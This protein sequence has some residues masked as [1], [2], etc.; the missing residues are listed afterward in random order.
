MIDR[1]L[2]LIVAS[3][4][5]VL[6]ATAVAAD[7][8]TPKPSPALAFKAQNID[9]KEVDLSRYQG[10]VLLIVNTA[11]QCGYTPQYEGLEAI[12][13]KY[14]GQ[15]FEILAFPANEFGHQEP[16]SNSEIKTFCSNNYHVTF[17]LFGKV[18]VKGAGI[19][20]LYDYLTST[21]TN[22]KFAGAIPWNFAKFLVDRNGDVVARFD[23]ADKP[24]SPKVTRAI[25]E[26]LAPKTSG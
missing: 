21:K 12:Y 24:E 26:A 25:E 1:I 17:P 13:K 8:P 5:W 15:G 18:V 10:K 6:V 2:C 4:P 3:L 23:P 14:K 19:H 22:P 7:S 20:P 9:G 16:G 11:S